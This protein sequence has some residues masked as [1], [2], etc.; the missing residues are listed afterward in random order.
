MGSYRRFIST[1]VVEARRVFNLVKTLLIQS[2]PAMET[3]AQ[4]PIQW[5]Y[6]GSPQSS[7]S[8]YR[9]SLTTGHNLVTPLIPSVTLHS[10]TQS[11]SLSR[12]G[13][14]RD[15]KPRALIT[16]ITGQDGSYLAELLLEKG[17]EVYGLIRRS[18][19]FNTGRID[20]IFSELELVFGDLTDASSL[21]RLIRTLKPTEIYHLGAQSHV[22]VSF[23]IPEYTTD[24]VALG[25]LRLLEA[26]RGGNRWCRFY[27]AG[28]SEMFGQALAPQNEATPFQ[29][30]SPYG[31]AK[32]F[33]HSIT[34]NYREAYHMYAINGI[35]FN[36]E[37]PRRGETFVT[38]K[39]SKAV[40]AIL[41]GEQTELRLG[42]LGARR[43][44]GYAK[45]YMEAVWLMMQ[46]PIADDYIIATGESHSVEQ[47]LEEAFSYAGLNWPE[48]VVIDKKY[49]RPTEIDHL[50]GD[51]RRAKTL[52]GWEPTVHFKELVHMM[53]DADK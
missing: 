51:A 48:F 37:S 42:N 17:Y 39:I 53:V 36:H 21:N 25:T 9:V 44:W 18:S 32:V 12:T 16:G 50:V 29:P 22:K 28:S 6:V 24:V 43:D 45:D 23:E 40:G 47:W 7:A 30:R 49:E 35:L 26:I 46:R 41:R 5:V 38:R 20:H 1:L 14:G 15:L 4:S 8:G 33:A 31:A 27:Q 10:G 52:L 2:L 19:S 13:L 34:R 3:R 11:Q